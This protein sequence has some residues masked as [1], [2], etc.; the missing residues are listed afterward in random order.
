MQKI[1]GEFSWKEKRESPGGKNKFITF[2]IILIVWILSYGIITNILEKNGHNQSYVFVVK[3]QAM[4]NTNILKT[5]QREVLNAWDTVR[6]IWNNSLAVLEWWDGSVTRL[7][8]NTSTQIKELDIAPD[9]TNIQIGFELL[10]WKTWS[11]IVSYLWG[12]SYFKQDFDGMSAAARGTIFNVDLDNQYLNVSDHKIQLTTSSGSSFIV[13]ATS[14]LDLKTLNPIDLDLFMQTIMDIDWESVNLQ[15]DIKLFSDLK[16]KAKNDLENIRALTDI[17]LSAIADEEKRSQM[18]N[19][20]LEQY[21]KLNF[22]D[23][24]NTELFATK[25]ELKN[26]LIQLADTQDKTS[27]VESTLYDFK[28]IINSQEFT[29]SEAVLEILSQNKQIIQNFD[30]NNYFDS[31]ILPEEIQQALNKFGEL[32]VI[33]VEKFEQLKQKKLDLKSLHD[34]AQQLIHDGLDSLFDK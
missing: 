3:W 7:A 27:L 23:A 28:D 34:S 16:Q 5:E 31:E 4:L 17:D 11:N 14:P 32:K 9:G 29:H 33:L 10:S 24:E 21:Q 13:D 8:G 15:E 22:V 18:Y 19:S 1:Q 26:T 30:F 20:V 25:L 2:I 12:E 6:T